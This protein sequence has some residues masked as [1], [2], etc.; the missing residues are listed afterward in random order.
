MTTEKQ[1]RFWLIGL[2]VFLVVLFFLRSVL[3]PF[4]LGMAI[5]YFLDPVC[6]RMEMWK[7]PRWLATVIVLVL[8]LIA[9][10]VALMLIV[11]VF[12]TQLSDLIARLPAYA[13]VLKGWIERMLALLQARVDPALLEKLKDTIEGSSGKAVAWFAQA[14]GGL[15]TQGAAIANLIA[16]VVIT[17]VVAFYLL[18]DWDVMVETVDGW[19]PRR[20][21]AVIRQ[22]T[23]EVNRTLAGFLRGQGLV[24]LVLGA[25]YAVGLTLAGLE[26][27]VV[28]GLLAGLLTFIPYAGSIFGLLIS[29]GLAAL[30]FDEWVRVAIV[31]VIFFVGQALEGNVLTPMLVGGRVGLHPVWVIFALLA[32]GALFGFVGVLI[33]VPAAAVM[34]VAV[35]FGLKLYLGSH[36]YDDEQGSTGETPV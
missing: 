3:L 5:A 33:A 18:R 21:A 20:H 10:I 28:I 31:A 6:D 25:F 4:V 8:F 9:C 12:T 27:G 2:V 15:L 34:G 36:Y 16:L 22:L 19:L 23:G 35:R 13:D 24:C 32:F 11:P 29:V 7:V 17:P 30:Q 14:A 1:I 26:F